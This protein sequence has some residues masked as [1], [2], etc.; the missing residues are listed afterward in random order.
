MNVER[1]DDDAKR[2]SKRFKMQHETRCRVFAFWLGHC[3]KAN[4]R[5]RSVRCFCDRQ[6][7]LYRAE[8]RVPTV[9]R[10]D[11]MSRDSEQAGKMLFLVRERV[12]TVVGKLVI[13]RNHV[14]IESDHEA[15]LYSRSLFVTWQVD[16]LGLCF[17]GERALSEGRRRG[18]RENWFVPTDFCTPCGICGISVWSE[19]HDWKYRS[20]KVT[21]RGAE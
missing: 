14:C 20:V 4:W 19:N 13:S 12:S 11:S 7:A 21:M 5:L 6:A 17:A 16:A 1:N 3:G 10:K 2:E 18:G 15:L 9:W 8:F